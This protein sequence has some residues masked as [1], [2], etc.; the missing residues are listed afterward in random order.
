[1]GVDETREAVLQSATAKASNVDI[2]RY[3]SSGSMYV[4]ESCVGVEPG[5]F[6][7]SVWLVVGEIGGI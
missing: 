6:V 7:H 3:I 1:M 2:E 4:F 5:L